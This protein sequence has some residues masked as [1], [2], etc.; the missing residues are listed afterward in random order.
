MDEPT[1]HLDLASVGLLETAL[2]EYPGALLL[3]GH[4]SLFLSRLTG[5]RWDIARRGQDSVLRTDG[6]EKEAA[7]FHDGSA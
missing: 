3:S 7:A 4:D 6:P 1:N 2:A 5:T